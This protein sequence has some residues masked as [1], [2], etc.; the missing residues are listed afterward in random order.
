MREEEK[1]N[2]QK[3]ER[4]ERKGKKKEERK[5]RRQKKKREQ[6]KKK[7]RNGCQN[8]PKTLEEKLSK[9]EEIKASKQIEDEG[10]SNKGCES[11][12]RQRNATKKKI[13]RQR[14]VAK[15]KDWKG[16]ARKKEEDGGKGARR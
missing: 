5:D 11:E 1:E 8:S 10:C 9:K 12:N 13:R 4:K 7:Q 6:L 14:R 2:K 3:E 15:G 16:K